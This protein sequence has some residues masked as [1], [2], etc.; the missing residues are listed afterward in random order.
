[1]DPKRQAMVSA[2]RRPIMTTFMNRAKE[3]DL[4]WCGTLF[5]AAASAQDA[6]MNLRQYEAFVFKAGHLDAENPIAEWQ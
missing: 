4:K 6:E 1:M 5:P 3:G 2:A